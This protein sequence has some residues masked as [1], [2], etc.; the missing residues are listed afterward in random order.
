MSQKVKAAEAQ[1]SEQ[2]ELIKVDMASRI[3]K[4]VSMI[5]HLLEDK[6]Q[7]SE[8]IEELIGSAKD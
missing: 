6:K 8:K 2:A 4:Q 1:G 3:E 5:E 7:L